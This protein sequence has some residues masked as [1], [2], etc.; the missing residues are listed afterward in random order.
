MK[1]IAFFGGS[2]PS[3]IGFSDRKQS[4][5]IYPNL[6]RDH[7]YE[8]V[9]CS[10]QGSSNYKI[11][12][13]CCNFLTN[14]YADIIVIEWNTFCRFWFSPKF[15]FEISISAAGF[16]IDKNLQRDIGLSDTDLKQIQK[17]LLILNGDYK[18]VIELF[19]YCLILQEFANTKNIQVAMINGSI[20]WTDKLFQNPDHVQNIFLETDHFTRNILDVEN[21]SDDKVIEW[22]KKIYEK[23]TKIN[24]DNWVCFSEMLSKLQIDSAPLDKHPGKLSH[25]IFADKILN[26]IKGKV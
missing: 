12:L 15:N 4:K 24:L 18:S 3:G 1:S 8:I 9:N 19:D 22:W 6:I 23:F 11:F 25:K 20:P 5:F 26:H 14:Q 13:S 2:I 21:L 10:E 17:Y 7:G 16:N